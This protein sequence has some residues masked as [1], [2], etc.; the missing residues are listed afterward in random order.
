MSSISS[1]EAE[2]SQIYSH[3]LVGMPQS[4]DLP[5]L[6]QRCIAVLDV[7]IPGASIDLVWGL[8]GKQCSLFTRDAA[9]L[10]SLAPRQLERLE[11]GELVDLGVGGAACGAAAAF[12]RPG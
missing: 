7:L 3:L 9:L 11:V 1:A 8:P 12:G 4:H 10:A 6:L 5:D 2:L